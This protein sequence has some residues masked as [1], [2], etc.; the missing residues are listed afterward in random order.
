VST[1]TPKEPGA[2]KLSTNGFEPGDP[3][4]PRFHN[5][6]RKVF[7]RMGRE[8]AV[9]ADGKMK[10]A[11]ENFMEKSRKL[12]FIVLVFLGAWLASP[13]ELMSEETNGIPGR[14]GFYFSAGKVFINN[15]LMMPNAYYV[16]A[17]SESDPFCFGGGCTQYI[18]HGRGAVGLTFSMAYWKTGVSRFRDSFFPP[19]SSFQTDYKDNTCSMLLFDLKA[20]EFP[21]RH[22]P[23][24][25][26]LGF[27]FGPSYQ[28]FTQVLVT[29]P[30]MGSGGRGGGGTTDA[31]Q[32]TDLGQ[33]ST[34]KTRTGFVIGLRIIP[35]RIVSI[36]L[37]YRPMLNSNKNAGYGTG[38]G[39]HDSHFTITCN[40]HRNPFF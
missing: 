11:K 37:D 2:G 27:A 9:Q 21:I 19:S 40:I 34:K 38:D 24:G 16:A 1:S 4:R 3:D 17:S 28:T 23:V 8:A 22:I 39:K 36:D 25:F 32:E 15:V 13:N 33:I 6:G 12:L 31:A 26:T 30:I 5:P 29:N 7:G 10:F 35:A 20:T 14:S 18:R